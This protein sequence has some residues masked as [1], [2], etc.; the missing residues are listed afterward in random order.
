MD[1]CECMNKHTH[2]HHEGK[3]HQLLGIQYKQPRQMCRQTDDYL[4]DKDLKYSPQN[5]FPWSSSTTFHVYLQSKQA[6]FDIKKIL[7][8]A[9]TAHQPERLRFL[10][11]GHVVVFPAVNYLML[12]RN[13]LIHLLYLQCSRLWCMYIYTHAHRNILHICLKVL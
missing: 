11:R 10:Q 4:H 1:R 2:E 9:L 6:G 13:T 3:L 8:A 7:T 12:S 5:L